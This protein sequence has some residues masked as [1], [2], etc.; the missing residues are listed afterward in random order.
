MLKDVQELS[1]D[2]IDQLIADH[3]REIRG[4]IKEIRRR[5]QFVS[6]TNR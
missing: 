2:Q 3:W 6:N 4:L 1:N 5:K